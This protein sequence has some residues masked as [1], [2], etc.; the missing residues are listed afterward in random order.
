MDPQLRKLLEVTYEA[1][2]D[3]GYNPQE[4]KGSKTGVFIGISTSEADEFWASN[5]EKANGY[6]VFVCIK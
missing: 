6:N 1:I 3:A 5:H 2:L 4:L